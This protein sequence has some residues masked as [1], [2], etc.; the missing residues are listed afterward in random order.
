MTPHAKFMFETVLTDGTGTAP[1][2]PEFT[3]AEMEGAKQAAFQSGRQTGREEAFAEASAGLDKRVADLQRQVQQLTGRLSAMRAELAEEAAS[4]AL[5]SV[6]TLIPALVAREPQ[7]ELAALFTECVN[8]L[9]DIPHLVV[10]VP[11]GDLDDLRTRLERVALETGFDG[12]LIL[13]QEE[14]MGAGD[15]RIEWAEGG[16]TRDMSAMYETLARLVARHTARAGSKT[17]GDS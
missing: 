7:A 4:L 6:R 9:R 17:S 3:R 8:H 13:L 5:A 15:C 1:P 16:I 10:R 11:P 12:K 2:E 14:E